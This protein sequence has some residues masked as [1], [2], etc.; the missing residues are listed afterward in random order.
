MG[1]DRFARA[2]RAAVILWATLATLHLVFAFVIMDRLPWTYP[3]HRGTPL[4]E[5]FFTIYHAH[6]YLVFAL[7][8]VVF[9][10]SFVAAAR[11]IRWSVPILFLSELLAMMFGLM[12]IMP[13]GGMVM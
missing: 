6:F 1:M 12:M 9:V 10:S 13:R 4:Y 7:S 2:Y 5:G 3:S 11:G 8:L